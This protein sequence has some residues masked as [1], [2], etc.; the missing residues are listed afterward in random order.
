ML[1]FILSILFIVV[2]GLLDLADW[3][4][5][6]SNWVL[7]GVISSGLTTYLISQHLMGFN[8]RNCMLEG[9][10]LL[11]AILNLS[12]ICIVPEVEWWRATVIECGFVGLLMLG[13]SCWQQTELPG[14]SLVC[15]LVVAVLSALSLPSVAGLAVVVICM[16]H[17]LCFSWHNVYVLLSGMLI[18]VWLIYC[19]L[20]LGIDIE[21]GNA[22]MIRWVEGWSELR[23][24]LPI[25]H[26]AGITPWLYMAIVPISLLFY[27][28]ISFMQ[29]TMSSLRLRSLFM[30]LSSLSILLILIMPGSWTICMALGGTVLLSHLLFTLGNNSTGFLRHFLS[31]QI[32]FYLILGIAEP[33]IRLSV[34]YIQSIDFSWLWNWWPF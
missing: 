26:A 28:I 10:A 16:A 19:S 12:A 3:W 17:L 31:V 24:G 7:A 27:V 1:P 32:Y 14:R 18:G 20:S 30:M 25:V 21:A 13:I 15:G 5:L 33:V 22:Y 34:I 23:Y 6:G 9:W 4:V 11:S 29:G 2:Q 8:N